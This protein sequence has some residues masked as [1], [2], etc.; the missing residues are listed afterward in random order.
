MS[1]YAG[2]VANAF[3]WNLA[4]HAGPQ[5]LGRAVSEILFRLPLDPPR[6]RRPDVAFVSFARWP[7]D[8]PVSYR[9]NAW[10][11]APDLVVEVASPTDFAEELLEKTAEYFRAGVRLVWLAYPLIRLVYVYESLTQVRGLTV[12]DE[13]DGGSVPPGF[14]TPLCALFPEMVF[15]TE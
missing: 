4:A 7:K 11:V 15:A 13:L 3:G 2:L 5:N 8:R 9:D 10:E 1:V 14:R 6:N 12:A